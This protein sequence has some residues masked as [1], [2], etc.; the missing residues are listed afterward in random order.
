MNYK[1]TEELDVIMFLARLNGHFSS[2]VAVFCT[3]NYYDLTWDDV[4]SSLIEEAEFNNSSCRES[5]ALVVHVHKCDF[6]G[7]RGHETER[8]WRN[9][10]NLNNRLSVYTSKSST[11]ASRL[12]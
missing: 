10:T 6:C 9:T 5:T 11:D 3:L 12:K 2:T 4:S 7:R 1:V 8:F